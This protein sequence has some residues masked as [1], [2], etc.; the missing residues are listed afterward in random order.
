MSWSTSGFMASS[1]YSKKRSQ[2]GRPDILHGWGDADAMRHAGVQGRAQFLDTGV[3]TAVGVLEPTKKRRRDRM[4]A[5]TEHRK[6]R[7]CNGK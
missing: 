3:E 2:W 4:Q 7:A 6:A 5:C 1:P